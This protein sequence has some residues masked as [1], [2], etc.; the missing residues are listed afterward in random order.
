MKTMFGSANRF[1]SARGNKRK[2]SNVS[3]E[4]SSRNAT[5]RISTSSKKKKKQ[6]LNSTQSQKFMQLLQDYA[7]KTS[8]H[9]RAQANET[10]GGDLFLAKT[11]RQNQNHFSVFNKPN[12]GR[13]RSKKRLG[14]QAKK[15]AARKYTTNELKLMYNANMS[16]V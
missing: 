11:M 12:T 15:L 10:A 14:S 13:T 1:N 5:P 8:K 2:L 16:G 9:A 4:K 7:P 3:Y 6:A